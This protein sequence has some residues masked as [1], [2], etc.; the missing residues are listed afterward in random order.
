MDAEQKEKS[1]FLSIIDDNMS[2]GNS[3]SEPELTKNVEIQEYGSK[4]RKS[5]VLEEN[6]KEEKKKKKRKR[7]ENK[8]NEEG[9]RSS[10]SISIYWP[11]F[12][13][14]LFVALVVA[15]IIYIV[16][17]VTEKFSNARNRWKI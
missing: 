12:V 6:K 2:D 16:V 5:L 10:C 7:E 14:F 8:A 1:D 3:S 17:S 11:G 4:S 9:G 13:L 15:L